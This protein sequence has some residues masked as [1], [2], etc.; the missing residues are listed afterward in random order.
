MRRKAGLGTRRALAIL[1]GSAFSLASAQSATPPPASPAPARRVVVTDLTIRG[2]ADPLTPEDKRWVRLHRYEGAGS[3]VPPSRLALLL[4][5]CTGCG[6]GWLDALAR[7]QVARGGVQVFTMERRGVQLEE[8]DVI[9]RLRSGA[10]KE[11]PGVAAHYL[12]GAGKPATW[13][14]PDSKKF[15]YILM[16]GMRLLHEDMRLAV[17]EIA[18]TTGLPVVAGGF[19]GGAGQALAFAARKF[20]DGR[21][22]HELIS[23]IV[24]L[25]GALLW[26]D[27]ETRERIKAAL[28]TMRGSLD[29]SAGFWDL[30]DSQIRTEIAAA[31]ALDDPVGRSPLSDGVVPSEASGPGMTNRAMFGWCLDLGSPQQRGFLGSLYQIQMGDL[32]PP[33]AP[34]SLVD[35]KDGGTEGEPTRLAQ[36]AAISRAP[37]GMFDW[38]YTKSLLLEDWDLFLSGYE[39][40]E[41][42][43]S[44][45]TRVSA[46][47]FSVVTKS[48]RFFP[49]KPPMS[50]APILSRIPARGSESVSV[51]EFAHS[52][53]L[54]ADSAKEKVFAPLHRWLMKLPGPPAR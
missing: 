9:E 35:W 37:G 45:L 15:P 19:S 33:A 44:E 16:W 6:T 46:P 31:L 32:Q 18:R 24:L 48:A 52:D 7:D 39:N 21:A 8:R 22:G 36:A 53:I 54:L 5:P 17:A 11:A 26:P 27:D 28:E 23:G 29:L 1:L 10:A 14:R 2:A 12:G 43:I 30:R 3:Q 50:I 34:G 41:Q 47:I 42:R 49:D 38:Y 13:E 25:D 20:E 4:L 40:V 51:L